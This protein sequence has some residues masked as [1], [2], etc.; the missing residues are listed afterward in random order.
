[1]D[2]TGFGFLLSFEPWATIIS[3][4]LVL[5]FGFLGAPLILWSV[6]IL[7]IMVG[8]NFSMTAVIVV[9]A[10]LAVFLIKPIR[11]VLVSAPNMKLLK[12]LGLA[13]AISDTERTALEAGVVWLDAD[14]FSG[15]PDFEKML[16]EPSGKLTAEEQAFLDG[17]VEELCRMTDD[18][19][20]TV[21]RE[22]PQKSWQ[23]LKQEKFLGM[24]IPKEYGGLGYSAYAHSCVIKKL[25]SRSIPL[26]ISVMVPNSLG[27]A[28]LLLHYGTEEQRK[29]M[30]PKLA[31][32]ELLPCFALTEPGAGSDAGAISSNGEIIKSSDGKLQIKLNWNKR[33]ITLAAISDILGLAFKL[34]DP[35]NYLGKGEDVGITCALIPSKTPGV[36]LGRRHDPLDIPFY[37]CPTQGENVIV[38]IDAII[39]GVD[40]AGKGWGMLM[41]CLSAGRG[42]S[43]PGQATGGSQTAALGVSAYASIRKQFGMSVGKFEGIED[44]LARIVGSS[45]IL[46]AQRRLTC[47]GLDKGIKPPVITAICKYHATELARKNINDAMDIVGGAGISRGPRNYLASAYMGMPIGITVEGANILTRTL[48]IF[49]QGALRAHPFAYKMIK[50]IEGQNVNDFDTAFWGLQGNLV[51]NIFRSV[52]LSVTRG[53][54][55]PSPV[56]GPHAKYFRKLSWASASFAVM[57]DVAMVSLGAGLKARGKITG[58]FAD[59]LSW[60]YFGFAVLH[61]FESEGRKQEDVPLLHYSMQYAFTQIQRAFDGIFENLEVPLLRFLFKGPIRFWSG[62]NAISR[63]V[64]DDI[65]REIAALA[66]VDS[67]QRR[68]LFYDGIFIGDVTQPVGRLNETFLITQK[69]LGIEKKLYKAIKRKELPKKPYLE[70]LDQALQKNIINKEEFELVK[71]A[72]E[73]RWDAVQVDSFNKE[74]YY[75]APKAIY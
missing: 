29:E 14:L 62:L 28:E 57:A 64:S 59:I 6:L 2:S 66:Q 9:A 35:N 58:R 52:L 68:R 74:E 1:M 75:V 61:R 72:E 10:I 56:S 11:R 17:P 27:P 40:G 18:W 47:G 45:Y 30:L 13:P 53:Y 70:I 23:F 48:M 60:M 39:G 46:E 51:R 12:K 41:D 42:I 8:F 65:S 71:K 24:I 22:L 31:R 32:G 73:M 55:A 54:L 36:I 50:S 37:N 33:Y 44:P 16:K 7:G 5:A 4:A 15:K 67:E 19:D 20:V 3:V 49:G 25:S 63:E 26:T 34:R 69:T 21:N 38:P 43:L